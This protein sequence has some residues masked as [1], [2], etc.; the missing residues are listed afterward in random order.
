LASGCGTPDCDWGFPMPDLSKAS[1]DSCYSDFLRH[2]AERHGLTTANVADHTMF[3][4]LV[5]WVLTLMK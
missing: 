1:F 3:L 5:N 4:D 2:C